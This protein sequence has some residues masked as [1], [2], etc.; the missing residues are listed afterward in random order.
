MIS[1]LLLLHHSS[2]HSPLPALF[3]RQRM[4]FLLFNNNDQLFALLEFLQRIRLI[5]PYGLKKYL[6]L[7]R[8]YIL[9]CY[10]DI[11]VA[12]LLQIDA[13]DQL[14]DAILQF[15]FSGSQILDLL[16]VDQCFVRMQF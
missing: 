12:Q 16:V 8:K 15:C 1:P 4:C 5:G 2:L 11:D 9:L 7:L 3:R 13:L 10:I 14:R 6:I